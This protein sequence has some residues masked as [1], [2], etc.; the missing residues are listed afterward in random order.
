MFNY[1]TRSFSI[2]VTSNSLLLDL[3]KLSRYI[4]NISILVEKHLNIEN[5]IFCELL[6][7]SIELESTKRGKM[8]P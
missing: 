6:E 1:N 5:I 4:S 2:K 7:R 3:H 8:K